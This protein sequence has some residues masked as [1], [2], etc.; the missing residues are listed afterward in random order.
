MTVSLTEWREELA[1][2][3]HEQWSGW[4][5]YMFKWCVRL[6]DGSLVIPPAAVER[7][8]KLADTPYCDLPEPSKDS[9]R[10]EANR[11]MAIAMPRT[12]ED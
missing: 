1:A 3:A 6:P 9:D 11:V 8:Q 5:C 4:M 2:L 7:W 10:K 12:R